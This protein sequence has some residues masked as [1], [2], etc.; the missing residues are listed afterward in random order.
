MQVLDDRRFVGRGLIEFEDTRGYRRA[1]CELGGSKPPCAGDQH[2]AVAIGAH[3]DRLQHAVTTD[4]GGQ[5]V[6]A[7]LGERA[8]RIGRRFVDGVGRRVV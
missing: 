1:A 6:E 7:G 4:A 8:P 5:F 3:E 2:E